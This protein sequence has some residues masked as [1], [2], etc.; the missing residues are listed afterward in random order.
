MTKNTKIIQK[1]KSKKLLDYRYRSRMAKGLSKF[2]PLGFNELS[3]SKWINFRS[4][5]FIILALH[6]SKIRKLKQNNFCQNHA[7]HIDNA[8]T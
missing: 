5:T 7:F 1:Q 6:I 3:I 2:G 8:I 4:L